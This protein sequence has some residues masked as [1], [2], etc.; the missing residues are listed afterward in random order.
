MENKTIKKVGKY[1]IIS[2]FKGKRTL[3]ECLNNIIKIKANQT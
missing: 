1:T 2:N 3:N